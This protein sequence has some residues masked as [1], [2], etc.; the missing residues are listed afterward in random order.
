MERAEKLRNEQQER[1]EQEVA[2]QVSLIEKTELLIEQATDQA[3][4][5]VREAIRAFVAQETGD[6]VV[7]AIGE[8]YKSPADSWAAYPEG[9]ANMMAIRDLVKQLRKEQAQLANLVICRR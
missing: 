9:Y 7:V 6:S 1:H 3:M 5:D 4:A 8:A 2:E